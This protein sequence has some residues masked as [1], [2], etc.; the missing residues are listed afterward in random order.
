[1][2]Y[3]M[4]LWPS[5]GS[6]SS[7]EALKTAVEMAKTYQAQLYALQVVNPV[8]TLSKDGFMP[9]APM[10]FNVPKYEDELCQAAKTFL[11]KTITDLVPENVKITAEVRVGEPHQVII[12]FVKENKVEL[13]VMA[14]HARKG[15]A[16]FFLGSVAEKV[17]RKSPVPVLTIPTTAQKEH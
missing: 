5:D 11:K 9:P 16:H 2:S 3:K 7:L 15:M 17:L 14:T 4:I 8:P 10:S 13:I 12:D 1:M 6:P